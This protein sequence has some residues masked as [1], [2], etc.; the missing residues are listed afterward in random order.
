MESLENTP[1]WRYLGLLI[2]VL[3]VLVGGTWLT[4]KV[5]TD[6]PSTITPPAPRRTG[7]NIWCQYE[8]SRAD[9]RRRNAVIGKHRL[10]GSDA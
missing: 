3:G 1:I 10:L 8:R 4:V 5:T 7:R 6:F 9:R 2:V